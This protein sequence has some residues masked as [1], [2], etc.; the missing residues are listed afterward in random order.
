MHQFLHKLTSK[1][2]RCQQA[3]RLGGKTFIS[4]PTAMRSDCVMSRM[5][6][7]GCKTVSLHFLTR[8]CAVG[9]ENGDTSTMVIDVGFVMGQLQVIRY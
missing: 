4:E 6:W 2:H 5:R 7:H 9:E 3:I 8:R 1:L